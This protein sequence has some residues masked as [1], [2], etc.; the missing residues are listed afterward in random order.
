MTYK[1]YTLSRM[2]DLIIYDPVEGEFTTTISGKK[3]AD[4]YFSHRDEV[5]GKVTQFSLARLAVWMMTDTL[6]ND[7][8]RVIYKDEDVYNLRYSN[9][10]VVPYEE[11]YKRPNSLKNTYLETDEDH[12]FVGTLNRLFVVR[13]GKKQ[14]VFRTYDKEEAIAVRDRWLASKKK[15]HELDD[16]SPKWYKKWLKEQELGVN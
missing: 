6:M 9:L 13:R 1:G 11:V 15:L 2:K 10:S 5:T 12:I 16:F 14:A 7:R 3:L 4:R 8:D